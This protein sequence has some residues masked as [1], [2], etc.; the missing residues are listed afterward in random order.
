MFEGFISLF[1]LFLLFGAPI[2]VNSTAVLNLKIQISVLLQVFYSQL[3][4]GQKVAKSPGTREKQSAGSLFASRK[5]HPSVE[6]ALPLWPFPSVAGCCG[7]CFARLFKKIYTR[8]NL[9]TVLTQWPATDG[10]SALFFNGAGIF[11][12]TFAGVT[13]AVCLCLSP[14][15]F[16]SAIWC[17]HKSEEL[18]RSD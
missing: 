7:T 15:F 14:C 18:S 8:A 17:S 10:A 5:R 13:C 9:Q 16:V 2:N 12:V 11:D 1:F 4:G 3:F 6:P